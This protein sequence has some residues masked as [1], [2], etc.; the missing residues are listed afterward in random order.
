MVN[1]WF[2]GLG[3]VHVI[4]SRKRDFRGGCQQKMANT[5]NL[6][7]KGDNKNK[8]SSFS[9]V[10]TL[11]ATLHKWTR[12]TLAHPLASSAKN[13]FQWNKKAVKLK[14]TKFYAL[15]NAHLIWDCHCHL[16]LLKTYVTQIKKKEHPRKKKDILSWTS[17]YSIRCLK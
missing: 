6:L 17:K 10:C 11:T 1:Q 16:I 5:N 12:I 7:I 9:G 13:M 8:Y 2:R 14:L 4:L 3:T 15:N